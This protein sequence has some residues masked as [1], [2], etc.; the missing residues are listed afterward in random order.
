MTHEF[1]SFL[2]EIEKKGYILIKLEEFSENHRLHRIL[3]N[4][5]FKIKN[6]K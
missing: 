4:P 2:N 6:L 5:Y 3:K 1:G